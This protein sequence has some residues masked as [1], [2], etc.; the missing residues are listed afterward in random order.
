MIRELVG[1]VH[2]RLKPAVLKTFLPSL[3]S[4]F[5]VG[6]SI[7]IAFHRRETDERLPRALPVAL[8]RGVKECPV[9]DDGP[10]GTCA[11]LV[12][13]KRRLDWVNE[14]ACVASVVANE[15]ERVAMKLI[16]S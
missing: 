7:G 1:R 11:E 13:M 2:E 12:Q 4:L 14:A 3:F 9:A 6:R 5:S 16:G 15:V 8:V 10:A